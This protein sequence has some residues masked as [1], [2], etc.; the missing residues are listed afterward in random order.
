MYY[1]SL[2]HRNSI[3]TWSTLP[4]SFT[5][6]GAGNYD[7]TTSVNKAFGDNMIQKNGKYCIYSGDVNND[8]IVDASDLSPIDND[9]FNFISGYVVT[10]LSGDNF[11]DASDAS[12]ADNNASNFISK[13]TP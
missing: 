7:F 3:E 6:G 5:S 12:I 10:D 13:I 9:A 11:V 8:G 1:I 4:Q 2:R